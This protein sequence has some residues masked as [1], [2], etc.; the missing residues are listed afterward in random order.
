MH[1]IR[2]LTIAGLASLLAACASHAPMTVA[3]APVAGERH[4]AVVA[5][6][7]GLHRP[8]NGLITAAQP[9]QEAWSALAAEGVTTVI[10]LRTHDEM[11]GRDQAAEVA[12]AGMAYHHLPIASADDLTD[13]N[14]ARL[15]A[16]IDNAGGP[17]LVHCASANRA[18]ALL[19]IGAA[20]SGGMTPVEAVAFGQSAG[21]TSARLEAEV[22]KRLGLAEDAQ[23]E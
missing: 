14:A 5:A 4:A 12:A 20:R 11:A 9:G 18:G 10:N 22:R 21:M 17:V 1:A 2:S 8:G 3:G 23:A 15:R 16:L 13:D 19:A 7:P 6:I